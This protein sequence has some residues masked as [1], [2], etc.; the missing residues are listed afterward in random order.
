[1]VRKIKVTLSL[2]ED[3]VRSVKSRLALEGRSLSEAVEELLGMY[4]VDGFFSTL[5]EELGLEKRFYTASEVKAG[6]P[7]G[8]R[9]EE[10]V[11]ELRDG[12][13]ESLLGH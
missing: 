11:R 12:R 3:L 2:R 13:E 10:V 7:S 8:Y 6:R 4:D 5:C 9:A 1:M